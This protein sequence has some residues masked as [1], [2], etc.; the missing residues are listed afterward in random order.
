MFSAI[1]DGE[2]G[3]L[4]D[5]AL[6][7]LSLFE[8]VTEKID[9]VDGDAGASVGPV[10]PTLMFVVGAAADDPFAV[11]GGAFAVFFL[12]GAKLDGF[13]FGK[14][15][16]DFIAMRRGVDGIRHGLKMS[17]KLDIFKRK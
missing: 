11:G 16:E 5:K 15:G 17:S 4:R 10:F 6:E 13:E 8:V 2:G 9:L 1:G 12:E 3:E 7:F 14:T